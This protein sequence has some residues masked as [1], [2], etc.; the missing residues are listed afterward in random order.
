MEL[1][2]ISMLSKTEESLYDSPARVL[3][4]SFFKNYVINNVED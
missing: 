1:T 4:C 2:L 3:L